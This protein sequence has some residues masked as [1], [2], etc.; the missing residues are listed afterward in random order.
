MWIFYKNLPGSHVILCQV[1]SALSSCQFTRM[2]NTQP[3]RQ[4]KLKA[5]YLTNNVYFQPPYT[6]II[7]VL[8]NS[9][10]VLR[11]V[12]LFSM[13]T[14]R[15]PLRIMKA[16][17]M[18]HSEMLKSTFSGKLHN[19]LQGIWIHTTNKWLDNIRLILNACNW[20]GHG[21]FVGPG[22]STQLKRWNIKPI[23]LNGSIFLVKHLN[24]L[25]SSLD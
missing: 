9:G 18:N 2:R 25:V 17:A 19:R 4:S 24:L 21:Q 10:K 15:Q 7:H 3:Q 11:C 13:P 5:F 16:F 12:C 1:W 23:F 6:W 22:G 14:E 20:P 8:L